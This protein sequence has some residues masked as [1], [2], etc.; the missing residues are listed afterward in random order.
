MNERKRSERKKDKERKRESTPFLSPT[1]TFT[2]CPLVGTIVFGYSMHFRGWSTKNPKNLLGKKNFTPDLSLK[3][4]SGGGQKMMSHLSDSKNLQI[5][6]IEL[7]VVP[8]TGGGLLWRL[9][10]S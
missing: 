4:K 7:A 2:K 5:C 3:D 6:P 1:I 8:Q 10:Y 9:S